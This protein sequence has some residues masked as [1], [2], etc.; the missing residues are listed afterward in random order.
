MQL[1]NR[2]FLKTYNTMNSL[3]E[4]FENAQF[5]LDTIAENAQEILQKKTLTVD[6]LNDWCDIRDILWN[7]SV[8]LGDFESKF[9]YTKFLTFYKA[10]K[11]EKAIYGWLSDVPDNK[12]ENF[13][14][15]GAKLI[16]PQHDFLYSNSITSGATPDFFA[17]VNGKPCQIECKT[18]TANSSI[19]GADMVVRH[20]SVLATDDEQTINFGFIIC[21]ASAH[22]PH[23]LRHTIALAPDDTLSIG[24]TGREKRLTYNDLSG[25]SE[26]NLPSFV[27][28]VDK[29]TKLQVGEIARDFLDRL[30]TTSEVEEIPTVKI[31]AP[32]AS[33]LAGLKFIDAYLNKHE[34]AVNRKLNTVAKQQIDNL[35]NTTNNLI[36]DTLDLIKNVEQGQ[37]NDNVKS[38]VN[39]LKDIKQSKP[40]DLSSAAA[41][42]STATT[43]INKLVPEISKNILQTNLETI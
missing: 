38:T 31:K 2:D 17:Q 36:D 41:Q 33:I 1:F 7:K 9:W 8:R 20:D 26:S 6:E 25:D 40:Q 28:A 37:L 11:A 32:F 5:R 22:S 21:Q 15:T 19:H 4:D 18:V 39:E 43:K 23:T 34:V 16:D 12:Y 3:W 30:K 14:V 29:S 27:L 35:D 24:K 13:K 10:Y 42:L